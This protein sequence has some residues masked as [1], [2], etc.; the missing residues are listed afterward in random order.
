MQMSVFFS[1]VTFM[2]DVLIRQIVALTEALVG[3]ASFPRG[4]PISLLNHLKRIDK[5]TA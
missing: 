4:A 5:S 2:L 3:N 1:Q